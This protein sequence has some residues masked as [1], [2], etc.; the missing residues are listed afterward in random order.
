MGAHNLA[1]S[2]HLPNT[3]LSMSLSHADTCTSQTQTPTYTC[4]SIPQHI[5]IIKIKIQANTLIC[6]VGYETVTFQ[7][8]VLK[9]FIASYYIW[10][11]HN[12]ARMSASWLSSIDY[13]VKKSKNS[14]IRNIF[15]NHPK[16]LTWIWT[17]KLYHRV[18]LL[19]DADGNANSVDSRSSLIW[20]GAV[21][22]G[23]SV[24]KL[25]VITVLFTWHHEKKSKS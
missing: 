25:R 20:V 24:R 19:K 10:L 1:F 9:S 3:K 6:H 7:N 2:I 14:D 8:I 4:T 23:L 5:W 11:F 12:K 22:P 18:M 15:C 13:T 17:T 16:I 21:C